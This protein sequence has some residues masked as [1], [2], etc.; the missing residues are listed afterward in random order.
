VQLLL[1]WKINNYYAFGVWVWSLSTQHEERM[2]RNVL[3]SVACLDLPSFFTLNH[4]RHDFRNISYWTC[5]FCLL[6]NFCL[7]QSSFC[8]AMSKIWWQI[9]IGLHIKYPLF[10]LY[11]NYIWIF[12]EEKRKILKYQISWKSLLVGD[13]LFYGDGRT[14]W[15]E[16]AKSLFSQF[17]NAPK[18]SETVMNSHSK[19]HSD[20]NRPVPCD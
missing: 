3:S 18:I 19:C 7:K 12:F 13:E 9:Y 20:T 16:E 17:L 4:K 11:F 15:N 6:Y 1:L 8:E 2:C 14:D 10:L 5:V